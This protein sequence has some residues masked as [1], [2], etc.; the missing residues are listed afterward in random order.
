MTQNKSLSKNFVYNIIYQ[1]LIIAV[2]LVLLPYTSRVLGTGGVKTYS[3][4][5]NV[6][7]YF[8]HLAFF[9]VQLYGT[10]AIGIARKSDF[11]LKQTFIEIFL[12][13][14]ITSILTIVL[15]FAT[16]PF[17]EDTNI[18]FVQSIW[19]FANLLD[20]TYFFT[21]TESLGKVVLKNA[22]VKLV[23]AILVLTLV[24][25]P[26]D[27]W[28]YV[29]ILA[30]GELVGQLIF[31]YAVFR[32][33][34]FKGSKEP[35]K[36]NP[37][38]HFKPLLLLFI[39]QIIILLYTNLNITMLGH[40]STDNDVAYFAQSQILVNTILVIATALATVVIPRISYLFEEKDKDK[41]VEILKKS[42]LMAGYIGYPMILGLF[43]T[44][45]ILIPWYLGDEFTG[46]VIVTSFLSLKVFFAIISNV[47]G[48][49]YLIPTNQNKHFIG[50]VS[51]GAFGVLVLNFMLIPKYGAMGA[52]I[53]TLAAEM[54]LVLY[55]LIVTVK[56]I[57]FFKL[58]FDT[59]KSFI[60]AIIMAL[61]VNV[62]ILTTFDNIFIY[63]S[64][65]FSE[66]LSTFVTIGGII[67]VGGLI[68]LIL[69]FILKNP[70]Q[71]AII[72]RIFKKNKVKN[73]DI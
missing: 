28:I 13:K 19:L 21:G 50:S 45:K 26:D 44:A 72:E 58:V 16:I 66:G 49:Q 9:G 18:L 52:V 34:L 65:Y 1:V 31:W 73:T 55:Q 70:N 7:V 29:V 64:N 51:L 40:F 60:S 47:I 3:V 23:T 71:I 48:I 54:L 4:T 8:S 17:L 46:A 57:N 36:L 68:Y 10:R 42:M 38:R 35:L 62:L 61:I 5:F 32:T 14:G 37:F 33:E 30:G 6:I 24:K 43:V 67:G 2:P 63:L 39:P 56:Q 12:L 11:K 15:F 59:Y 22:F 53:A 41:I 20:I 69:N 25:T 27:L